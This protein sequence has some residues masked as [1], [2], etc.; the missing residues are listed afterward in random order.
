MSCPSLYAAQSCIC[1]STLTRPPHSPLR[2]TPNPP[3]EYAHSP[4]N[5][6]TNPPI[7]Y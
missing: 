2:A 3:H 5:C 6:P 7:A 4:Q 1:G